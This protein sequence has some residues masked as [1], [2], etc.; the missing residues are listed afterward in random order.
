MT[1]QELQEALD[2]MAIPVAAAEAHGWLCGAL[3]VRGAYGARDWLCDLAAD[4]GAAEDRKPSEAM[5]AIHDETLAA[6]RSPEFEFAPL[7][8]GDDAPL[9]ER[10]AGLAAWCSGFLYGFGSSA[11]A[12]AIGRTGDVGEYLGDLS[13][14]ARAELEAGRSA[15]AGEGDFAELFEFVRAGTQLAWDELAGTRSHAAG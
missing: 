8:P 1:H 15:E 10:V 12:G 5:H 2:R 11:P 9:G 4:A 7:V 14:I 3:C 6:L 13:S